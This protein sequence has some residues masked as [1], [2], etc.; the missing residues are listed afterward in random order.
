MMIQEFEKKLKEI[1]ENFEIVDL[2]QFNVTD[3]KGVRYNDPKSGKQLDVCACPAMEIL[4]S[5]SDTF[6]DDFGRPHKTIGEVTNACL[7][8][9]EKLKNPEIYDLLTLTDAELDAKEAKNQ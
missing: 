3:I 7:G 9:I 8:F 5:K 4:E 6:V 2:T 1:S